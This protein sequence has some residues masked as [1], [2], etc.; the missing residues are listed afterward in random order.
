MK[1]NNILYTSS[2]YSQ[3]LYNIVRNVGHQPAQL[4]VVNCKSSM[5]IVESKPLPLTATIF[6]FTLLLGND[7]SAEFH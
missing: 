1:C 5:A 3:I 2:H 7:T 4:S 6:I